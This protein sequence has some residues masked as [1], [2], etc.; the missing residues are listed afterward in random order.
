MEGSVLR[1]VCIPA[2]LTSSFASDYLLKDICI[3]ISLE[4]KGNSVLET[5]D[6]FTVQNY[7]NVFL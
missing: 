3:E 4:D 6:L 2:L 1:V 7:K 5:M